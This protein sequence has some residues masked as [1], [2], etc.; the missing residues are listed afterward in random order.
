LSFEIQ[1]LASQFH[2][3]IFY[4][5]HF[6]LSLL[7]SLPT[8]GHDVLCAAE[9]MADSEIAALKAVIAAKDA[10]IT[11]KDAEI[12]RLIDARPN[13]RASSNDAHSM[14]KLALP[15]QPK[16]LRGSPRSEECSPPFMCGVAN[17]LYRSSLK[18]LLHFPGTQLPAPPRLLRAVRNE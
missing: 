6:E 8:S 5:F 12:A 15:P 14:R 4:L 9:A 7:K 1:N 13:A 17:C 3:F 18:S 16:R 10:E 11:A 2:F